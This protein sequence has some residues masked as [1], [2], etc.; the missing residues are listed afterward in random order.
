V[1]ELAQL[2]EEVAAPNTGMCFDC[3]H[4]NLVG[5]SCEAL[6]RARGRAIYTHISDNDGTEDSHKLPG[7][8]TIDFDALCA[9]FHREGYEGTFMLECFQPAQ[10]LTEL[11]DAGYARTLAR[12]LAIANGQAPI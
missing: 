8:G 4:A 2:L 5:D 6:R 12:W 9:T 10:H 1:G 11:L 3:A 7:E